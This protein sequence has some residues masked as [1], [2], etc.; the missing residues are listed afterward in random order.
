MPME[1]YNEP[2]FEEDLKK[3]I[4][5]LSF[6]LDGGTTPVL[7]DYCW[8]I[9]LTSGHLNP[10]KE[11][12]RHACQYPNKGEGGWALL[13]RWH[14]KKLKALNLRSGYVITT[15]NGNNFTTFYYLS[16]FDMS[17]TKGKE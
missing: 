1:T 9:K 3:S 6:V 4:T 16:F 15:Y 7:G 17:C 14:Y 11:C 13:T 5:V 10:S 2:P 8:V 12:K